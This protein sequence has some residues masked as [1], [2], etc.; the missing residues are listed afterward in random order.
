MS[1]K[2]KVGWFRRDDLLMQQ[3]LLI[4]RIQKDKEYKIY[5]TLIPII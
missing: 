1:L 3:T 4:Y 2:L 5:K